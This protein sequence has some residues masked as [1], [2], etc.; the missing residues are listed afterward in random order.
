MIDNTVFLIKN[1]KLTE[2]RKGEY[3]TSNSS[4]FTRPHSYY[5][6]FTLSVSSNFFPL[7]CH[8]SYSFLFSSSMCFSSLLSSLFSY[9]CSSSM[10]LVF[11]APFPSFFLSLKA[12]V[13]CWSSFSCKFTSP[14]HYFTLFHEWLHSY[15][16]K[17]EADILLKCTFF[18]DVILGLL[19]D[20]EDG[21]RT[22]LQNIVVHLPNYKALHP[23]DCTCRNHFCENLKFNL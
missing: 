1:N 12:R 14:Y 11:C 20:P 18:W 2:P 15:N 21:C 22:F 9:I 19:F 13:Y 10:F 6:I 8:L 3:P 7:A 16:I 5:C 23:E 4:S 17:T